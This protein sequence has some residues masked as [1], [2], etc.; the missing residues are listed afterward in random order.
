MNLL[1]PYQLLGVTINSTPRE[2]KK[3]YYMLSLLCHPDK[4]GCKKDMDIVHKAYMYVKDQILNNQNSITYEEAEEEFE[5]FC[6]EQEEQP[7]AFS[8]IYEEANDFIKDFNREFEKVHQSQHNPFNEGYGH[9]MEPSDSSLLNTMGKSYD[10]QIKDALATPLKHKFS[11]EI[12]IYKEPQYLPNTYGNYYNFDIKKIDDFSDKLKKNLEGT[13]Y[14]KAFSPFE[15]VKSNRKNYKNVEEFLE[16]RNIFIENL[17]H[18][19]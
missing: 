13:D 19:L 4:G 12:V 15:K 2:L 8:K 5:R 6:K 18:N 11:K 17:R 7:P 16:E 1:N 3:S 9:L 10:T 14:L